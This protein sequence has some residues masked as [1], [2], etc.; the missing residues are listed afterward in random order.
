MQALH[1]A[2]DDGDRLCACSR[3]CMEVGLMRMQ[4]TCLQ[5]TIV[6]LLQRCQNGGQR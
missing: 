6:V 5:P 2:H 3:G 1:A 4:P